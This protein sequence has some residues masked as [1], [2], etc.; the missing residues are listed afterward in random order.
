MCKTRPY[1]KTGL[2]IVTAYVGITLTPK[3]S[4]RYHDD[5]LHHARHVIKLR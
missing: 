5:I 1:V 2:A 4:L 3:V